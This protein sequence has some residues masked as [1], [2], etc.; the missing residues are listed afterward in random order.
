MQVIGTSLYF[1]RLKLHNIKTFYY[2]LK[3]FYIIT[4]NWE[5]LLLIIVIKMKMKLFYNVCNYC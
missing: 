3:H 2:L 5:I 4:D 1:P